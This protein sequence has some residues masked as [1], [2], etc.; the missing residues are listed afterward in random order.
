MC[1]LRCVGD[2][3]E[4]GKIN[5]MM[6]LNVRLI[7][8]PRQIS[9]VR[10]CSPAKSLKINAREREWKIPAHELMTVKIKWKF[11]HDESHNMMEKVNQHLMVKCI[12]YLCD[13]TSCHTI[14]FSHVVITLANLFFLRRWIEFWMC[15]WHHFRRGYFSTD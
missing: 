11:R 13:C 10:S 6:T 2:E 4:E 9:L 12:K 15:R 7:F 8:I 14:N 5:I 1:V 3:A